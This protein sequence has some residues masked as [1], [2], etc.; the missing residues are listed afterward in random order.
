MKTGK[1][2]KFQR[3]GGEVHAYLYSE[4]GLFQAALYL[5]TA[6][7]RHDKEPL[8]VLRGVTE[9]RL[10]QDVRAWVDRHFPRSP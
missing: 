10:E 2:M 5:M 8:H 6:E 4:G 7:R 1:L 3:P 9:V